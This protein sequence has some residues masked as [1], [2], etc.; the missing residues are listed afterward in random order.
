[1]LYEEL[2]KMCCFFLE[3][4]VVLAESSSMLFIKPFV[5][6]EIPICSYFTQD[7]RQFVIMSLVMNVEQKKGVGKKNKCKR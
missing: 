7:I 6:L 4:F 2:N 1:M 3:V 5:F